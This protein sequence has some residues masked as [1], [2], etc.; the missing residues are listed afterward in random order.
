L[1]LRDRAV[2]RPD[3]VVE[4]YLRQDVA[5][6]RGLMVMVL[7]GATVRRELDRRAL[8]HHPGVARSI[9]ALGDPR[10]EVREEA[11]RA[12]QAALPLVEDDLRRAANSPD[13]ERAKRAQGVL[14]ALEL[15]APG[16]P[17]DR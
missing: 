4:A 16:H 5:E 3:E 15:G 12:L 11:T 6:V 17:P 14:A 8:R 2:D 9:D 7:G 10:F 1:A 13:A